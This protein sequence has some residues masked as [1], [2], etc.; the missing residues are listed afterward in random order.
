MP[1][2]SKNC[3]KKGGTTLRSLL[4]FPSLLPS[5]L[6]L[7]TP[8]YWWINNKKNQ[9][10]NPDR[11]KLKFY[12]EVNLLPVF[13]SFIFQST[14]N[15]S[16]ACK[17]E[18]YVEYWWRQIRIDWLRRAH[19][20][21]ILKMSYGL[22]LL[23]IESLFKEAIYLVLLTWSP[24]NCYKGFFFPFSTFS[25]FLYRYR[26]EWWVAEPYL[27]DIFILITYCVSMNG[28]LLINIAAR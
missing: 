2:Q 4:L 24:L 23:L 5:L 21:F 7:P 20:L 18:K 16:T 10:Q 6:F 27:T 28:V 22:P 8:I 13:H 12:T 25:C 17:Q 1:S 14:L 15:Q 9:P 11:M 26:K 19:R 3:K